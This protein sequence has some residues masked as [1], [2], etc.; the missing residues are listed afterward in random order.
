MS[1]QAMLERLTPNI[2]TVVHLSDWHE[3]AQDQIDA[4]AHATG[5]HQW[6][7]VDVD[8]AR[9]ESPFGETIAHG[10]LVLSL[11]PVLRGHVG[12]TGPVY[13]GVRNVLNY[14]LNHLRFMNPVTA[15]A[16]V[17]GQFEL[18]SVEARGTGLQVVERYTVE[19]EGEEKPACVAETVRLFQF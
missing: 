13:P 6:I 5:D 8:R 7:H 11:V 4:F 10:Y 2:G 19:I 14:G 18:V 16:R 9:R 1:Q 17:R 15:G 12:G 3:V